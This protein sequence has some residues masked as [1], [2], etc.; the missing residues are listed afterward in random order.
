[1]EFATCTS[2]NN[3]SLHHAMDVGLSDRFVVPGHMSN[4]G[5][6]VNSVLTPKIMQQVSPALT[7]GGQYHSIRFA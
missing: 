2:F 6:I 4:T 3:L 5:P 7:V 1:M